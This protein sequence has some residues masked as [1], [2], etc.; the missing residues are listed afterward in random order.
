MAIKENYRIPVSLGESPLDVEIAITG[1]SGVGPRPIPLGFLLVWM[2]SALGLMWA[3][4]GTFIAA[5]PL[6]L[7]GC[8]SLVWLLAT[9]LLLRRD[10]LGQQMWVYVVPAIEYLRSRSRSLPTRRTEPARPFRAMVGI[11]SVEDGG[12]SDGRLGFTDGS[13]GYIYEVVGNGSRLLFEEDRARIVSR[14][15]SFF[16]KLD[17]ACQYILVS[18]KA[19]MRVDSQ[20]GAMVRRCHGC[21]DDALR[22]LI[23]AKYKVLKGYVGYE[24][25]STHQYLLVRAENPES[26]RRCC[27]HVQGEAENSS[28]VFKRVERLGAREAEAVVKSIFTC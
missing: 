16:R 22:S 15:D 8:F 18:T 11:A 25:R 12:R 27:S 13:C 6:W 4:T 21:T 10:R 20:C 19:P 24:F 2:A 28:L 17:V 5:G 26:L 1:K 7:R 23:N 9:W 3:V 14:Y